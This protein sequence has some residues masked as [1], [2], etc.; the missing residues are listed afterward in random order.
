MY[1]VNQIEEEGVEEKF[2]SLE[3]AEIR[4]I[5]RCGGDGN[6]WVMAVW[7][8]GSGEI[9]SIVWKSEVFIK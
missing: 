2:E 6:D 3:D 1:R 8:A 4:A 5:E 7:D 9:V